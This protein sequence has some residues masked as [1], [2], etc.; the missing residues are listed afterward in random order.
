MIFGISYLS[1]R[2][3]RSKHDFEQKS[4]QN[5]KTTDDAVDQISEES[6]NL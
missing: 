2:E 6:M 3:N 5:K 4:I 1:D